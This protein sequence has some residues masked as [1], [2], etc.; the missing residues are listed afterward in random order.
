MTS[1]YWIDRVPAQKDNSFILGDFLKIVI[2]HKILRVE[3]QKYLPESQSAFFLKK[4]KI[5]CTSE[6]KEGKC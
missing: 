1:K 2:T 3:Y 6:S 5:E 4:I